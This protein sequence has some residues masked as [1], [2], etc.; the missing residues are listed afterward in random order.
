MLLAATAIVLAGPCITAQSSFQSG[1]LPSI[2]MNSRITKGWRLNTK[3]ESRHQ[4]F[5]SGQEL[6]FS[7]KYDYLLTDLAVLIGRKVRLRNALSGGFL[8][9]HRPGSTGIRLVQQYA[10][11]RALRALRLGHRFSADQTWEKNRAAIFRFRYRVSLEIPLEGVRVD[12]KEW[13]VKLNQEILHHFTAQAYHM[14]FRAVPHLG[15]LFADN[16]KLEIGLDYRADRLFEKNMRHS[17]WT[18]LSWYRAFH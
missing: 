1:I 11:T 14:E 17:L 10:L 9:R 6:P 16:S 5:R 18:R 2:N 13:Y 15:Y 8:F 4:L 3:L 7:A 12:A